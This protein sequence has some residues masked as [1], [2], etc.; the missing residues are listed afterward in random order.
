MSGPLQAT[1]VR[2]DRRSAT[3]MHTIWCDRFG[4]AETW[5]RRASVEV[6]PEPT[7]LMEVVVPARVL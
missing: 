1:V 2:T 3:V 5:P 7:D 4:G 6:A